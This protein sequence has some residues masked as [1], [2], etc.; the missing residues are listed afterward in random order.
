[1][2]NIR[3]ILLPVNLQETALPVALIRQAAALAHH[4]HSEI[5][6]LHV[7]KPLTYMAGGDTVRELIEQAVASGQEKL[8]TYLG[9]ELDGSAVRRMVLKGDPAREI[10]RIVHDEKID[11]IVMPTHGYGAFERFLLGSVTAKVLHNSGCPVWIGAHVEDV[12][13]QQFAIRT[14]LCAV[15]FSTHSP[16]TIRWAQDVAAEFGAQLTL[17]HATPSVEIYGPGGYHVLYEMKQ[18]LVSSATKQMAEIQQELGTKA[19]IFIGSGDV[20]KVMSQA[21]KETKA[22][23]LVVGCRSPD[24]RLGTSAYGII[25]E[26]HVPVLS[27]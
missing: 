8:K 12:P 5:L 18:E 13:S 16:K 7:V 20:P 22:D 4:F 15:D 25:R 9:P 11:L 27:I 2:L 6:I 26:S 23:L 10:L 24:R 14:V 1:L 19:E 3:K 17:A 21:A